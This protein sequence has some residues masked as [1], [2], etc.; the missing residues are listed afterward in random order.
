MQG[1]LVG[2]SQQQLRQAL[3]T[4]DAVAGDRVMFIAT[5]NSI[6]N[7][8]TALKSRFP[9]VF[10]FDLP[11]NE[12]IEQAWKIHSLAFSLEEQP[13][14]ECSGW[15]GRNV[16]RCC[17][18]AYAMGMTIRESSGFII[19]ESIQSAKEIQELRRGAIGKYLSTEYPGPYQD[20]SSKKVGTGR[21]INSN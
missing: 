9:D 16:Q 2:Q 20:P 13:T 4:I 10:F 17:Q 7:L 11:T 18:K 6:S 12:Q 1:S 19:P 14:P 21:K 3:K 15:S 8:D 5:S